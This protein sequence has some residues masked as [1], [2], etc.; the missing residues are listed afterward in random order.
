M[1]TCTL[2]GKVGK[3]I[4]K[5]ETKKGDT[6]T[7]FS[8]GCSAEGRKFVD[9]IDVVYWKDINIQEGMFV[10]VKGSLRKDKY[11]NKNGDE[12][13]KTYVNADQ[14]LVDENVKSTSKEEA[15]F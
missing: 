4:R 15:P 3:F 13:Y 14:V 12:V 8:V 5:N 2:Y 10:E 11:T 9:W 1:N 7:N 6:V